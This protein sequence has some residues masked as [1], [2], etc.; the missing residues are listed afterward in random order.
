MQAQARIQ[1]LQM[2][3]ARELCCPANFFTL[4]NG[5]FLRTFLTP[6]GWPGCSESVGVSCAPEGSSASR[7]ASPPSQIA[8]PVK[9]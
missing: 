1:F 6:A 7:N 2:D 4:I 8:P 3:F 5:C 9:R